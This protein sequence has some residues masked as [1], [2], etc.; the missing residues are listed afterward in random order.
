M[1][2]LKEKEVS[3]QRED[4]QAE[5]TV[6]VWDVST[7]LGVSGRKKERWWVQKCPD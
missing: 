7:A 5:D 6:K 3:V 4:F 2:C 1:C